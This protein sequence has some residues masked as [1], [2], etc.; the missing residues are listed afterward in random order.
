MTLTIEA[1]VEAPALPGDAPAPEAPPERQAKPRLTLRQA[2]DKWDA[3]SAKELE[4]KL[5]N[6]G[7]VAVVGQ[8]RHRGNWCPLSRALS[9][10]TAQSIF[11]VIGHAYY[12]FPRCADDMKELL[13]RGG[14]PLSEAQDRFLCEVDRGA[15]PRLAP[16]IG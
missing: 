15:Y 11:V 16:G 2:L 9:A 7:M 6:A 5:W 12:G 4:L 8:R 14:E 13:R 3:T 10:E 1:P